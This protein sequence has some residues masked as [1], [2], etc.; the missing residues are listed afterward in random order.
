MLVK[1]RPTL[2]HVFSVAAAAIV[3]VVLVAFSRFRTESRASI[4]RASETLRE[5]AAHRVEASVAASLGQAKTALENIERSI[6]TGAVQPD[7]LAAL[8]VRLFTE[9]A[10]S[11]RLEEVTFTRAHLVSYD[12]DGRA[13]FD[14][15][16]RFQLAVYRSKTGRIATRL[17]RRNG[18]GFVVL[19]RER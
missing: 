13:N 15:P 16:G 8:E 14:P 10:A 2:G 19:E 5:S 1:W 4:A 6:R 11:A 17:T 12:A 9:L 18:D 3:V 7:D